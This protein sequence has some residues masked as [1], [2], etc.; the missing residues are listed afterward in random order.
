MVLDWGV[1]LL[2]QILWLVDS[3]V[4]DV[5]ADLSYILGE[6]VDDGFF[7][8]ITFEN[9]VKAIVEV[10]DTPIT[11]SCLA[12]TLRESEGTATIQDWALNGKMVRATGREDVAAPKPVQA[13]CWINENN[14]TAI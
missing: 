13:R 1:H 12:G 6:E 3:P 7:A 5:K 10:G 4:K 14:G 2:D 11:P 9:G 8:L